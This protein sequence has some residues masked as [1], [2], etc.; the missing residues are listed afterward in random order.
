MYTL[1]RNEPGSSVRQSD[2]MATAS[3]LHLLNT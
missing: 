3:R 2:V 1:A